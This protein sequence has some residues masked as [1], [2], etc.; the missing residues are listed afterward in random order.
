MT[1]FASIRGPME[2]GLE[3]TEKERDF[4]SESDLSREGH[5]VLR[6]H[7]VDL[8]GG[9]VSLVRFEG[10]DAYL[11]ALRPG[12]R[13]YIR[14]VAEDDILVMGTEDENDGHAPGIRTFGDDEDLPF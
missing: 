1:V 7:L 2:S 8:C 6:M 10:D 4:L 9:V 12:S 13:V 11:V 14:N 5:A 3:L